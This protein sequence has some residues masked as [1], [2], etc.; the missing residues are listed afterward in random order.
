MEILIV[1]LNNDLQNGSQWGFSLGPGFIHQ[2]SVGTF[3]DWNGPPP[4]SVM[5]FHLRTR[6]YT[7]NCFHSMDLI[8]HNFHPA[9]PELGTDEA[10]SP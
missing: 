9:K 4:M 5:G 2:L 10:T 6:P 1:G 7:S 3:A 8:S